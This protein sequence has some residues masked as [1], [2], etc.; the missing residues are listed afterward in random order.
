M[1]EA[2][3]PAF[4]AHGLSQ[5]DCF[6]DAFRLSATIRTGSVELAKLGGRP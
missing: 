6:S 5:D 3:Y 4:Q 1:V 2:A